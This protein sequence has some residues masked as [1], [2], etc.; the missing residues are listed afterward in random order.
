M[1]VSDA[2]DDRV[3]ERPAMRAVAVAGS[4]VGQES[5]PQELR[6][7]VRV[8]VIEPGAVATE[9]TDHITHPETKAAAEQM[10]EQTSITAQDIVEV[11]AFA[12]SRPQNVSLN[13]IL[14]RPTG[15][16]L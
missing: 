11:I 14:L 1:S 7:D 6:P 16:A 8:I 2:G 10:Y 9:R 13:E 4:T 12:V 15:Q 3:L 5:L